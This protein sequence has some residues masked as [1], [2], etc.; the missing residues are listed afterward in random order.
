M[1]EFFLLELSNGG[2]TEVKS[3]KSLG[4]ARNLLIAAVRGG[5][6][7]KGPIYEVVNGVPTAIESMKG[8]K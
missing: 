6:A 7:D 5:K 1:E 2:E 4:L 8:S 3:H